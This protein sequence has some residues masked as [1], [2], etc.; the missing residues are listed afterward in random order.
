MSDLKIE[1]CV[2][3]VSD[4]SG[5][6]ELAKFMQ[7]R[8]VTI[9]STGG[10]GKLLLE[11]GVRVT[12][13]REVTGNEHDDYFDGRMKTLSFNYE[14]A[15]LY[16]R[17]NAKH[18]A[19][20][21]ELGVP[22]I[23]MVVCNLYPFEKV[24]CDPECT[25]DTAIENIDIGGPCMVRAAAKNY[26]HVAVVTNPG[27]YAEIMAEMK[28]HDGCVTKKIR[29]RLA[30][31][32]F[33][34]T[35]SY[36]STIDQFF[37]HRI[38]DEAVLRLNYRNGQ[39]LGRYAENWHQKGW[40]FQSPTVVEPTVPHAKQVHGGSLG[41]NNYL[42]AES[43]LRSVLEQGDVTAV[44]IIKHNNPC[45]YATG[46]TLREAIE[47]GWQGDP[48]S[49]FGS[50]IAVTRPFDK[51]TAEFLKDKFVEVLL[52]PSISGETLEYIKSLGKSKAN[53]RLFEYGHIETKPEVVHMD[54]RAIPGGML[55]QVRDEKFYLT[56]NM[57]ELFKPAFEAECENSGK[58]LTIGI[59]TKAQPPK[60]RMGLYEFALRHVRHVKSNAI[61]IYRE[62]E[63]GKYQVLGMGCGQPNRK[64]SVMLAG[65]RATDNIGREFVDNKLDG[66]KDEYV[67]SVLAADNVVLVSDAMFP[68]RDGLDNAA[69]TGVKYVIQPGGSMRDEEVIA[70]ADEHGIAMVHTGVRKFYH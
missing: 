28:E 54:Y 59:V 60:D 42:D 64:D 56:E 51:E 32:A 8:G 5:I 20:A 65:M 23:D 2:M 16:K 55:T 39:Q 6:V 25:T 27:M 61:C 68:F 22:K 29:A 11:N 31:E 17:D 24:T 4:K 13:I 67:R 58:K 46:E 15:L 10:T 37:S 43:A 47:R 57:E 9:I 45:G 3:S 33:K 69:S 34:K 53:F 14:S 62:Y 12:A 38:L 19:Q 1:T 40:L 49:A 66:N 36:D 30:V 18:V 44:S 48:V 41:Y 50:V 63:P 70:A 52:A 7:E 21:K 35:A 26:Y